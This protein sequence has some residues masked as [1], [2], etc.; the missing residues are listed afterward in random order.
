MVLSAGCVGV[1]QAADP[2]PNHSRLTTPDESAIRAIHDAYVRGWL[3]GDE[4]GVMALFQDDA[5]ISPSGLRPITGTAEIRKFWFPKDGSV[6]TIH[7]FTSDILLLDGDDQ[8]AMTSQKT[9]LDWSWASAGKRVAK[10]QWG[11]ATTLYCKQR[12]GTWRIWRQSWTDVKSL[13]K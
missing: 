2:R 11:Y 7:H 9:R 10:E 1:R 8:V 3:E 4:D 5:M 6:T 13:N 12:D